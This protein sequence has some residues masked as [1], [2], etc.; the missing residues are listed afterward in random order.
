M[1]PRTL[2]FCGY[3]AVVTLVPSNPHPYAFFICTIT[4]FINGF[5]HHYFR[6]FLTSGTPASKTIFHSLLWSL[7]VC[8]QLHLSVIAFYVLLGNLFNA[9]FVEFV[10]SQPGAACV[11]FTPRWTSNSI[12]LYF[13]FLATL[14]LIIALKPYSLMQLNQERTALQLNILVVVLNLVDTGVALLTN[15][16]TCDVVPAT[17][18]LRVATGI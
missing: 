9:F 8:Y 4:L 7:S 14:K 10:N 11:F 1:K 13:F 16:T 6:A 17:I 18:F 15:G 2:L 12:F 5:C 3:C